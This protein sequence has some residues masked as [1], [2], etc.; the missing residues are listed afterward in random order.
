LNTLEFQF[1]ERKK[2]GYVV[3]VRVACVWSKL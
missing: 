3:V 2:S 1:H